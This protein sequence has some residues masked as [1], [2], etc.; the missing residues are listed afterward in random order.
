MTPNIFKEK[1]MINIPAILLSNHLFFIKKCPINDAESPNKMNIRV[2]PAINPRARFNPLKKLG[3]S[4]P[5]GDFKKAIYAGIMGSKQG[6]KKEAKPAVNAASK[7]T[8]EIFSWM[9]VFII[10]LLFLT[11][12]M[13]M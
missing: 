10:L 7:L 8:E 6:A 1:K 5:S 3:F 13:I 9:M 11:I 12:W 4:S 2:N